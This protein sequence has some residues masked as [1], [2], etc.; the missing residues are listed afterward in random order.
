MATLHRFRQLISIFLAGALAAGFS[1]FS[2]VPERVATICE[3]QGSWFASPLSGQTVTTGGVV[4]LDRDD[5][6]L[7]G[8]FIQDAD[9]DGR[10]T[11]SD[12]VFVSL[13]ERENVVAAGD[14]VQVTGVVAE[15]YGRTQIGSTGNQVQVLVRGRPLPAAVELSLPHDPSQARIQLE[16]LEGMH[17]RIPSARV[18]APS[19]D[20]GVVWV[21]R[22]DLNLRHVFYDDPAG[23]GE[24][25]LISDDGLHQVEPP[26]A[27]GDLLNGVAGVVDYRIGMYQVH[28]RNAPVLIPGDPVTFSAPAAASR[29][30]AATFNLANLFDTFDDP[31]TKDTVLGQTEYRR[32]LYKR[33]LAIRNV[34]GEPDL[35]AVQEAE[36][37]AVL[38]SLVADPDVLRSDYQVV[39]F[40]GPDARGL[41]VALLYRADRLMVDGAYP[42]QGC[43]RLTDGLGPDGGGDPEQPQ[44]ALTCDSDG[45]GTLDGN[46]LFSRPPLVVQMR[47]YPS[48]NRAIE[49]PVDAPNDEVLVI[50]CHFKSKVEDTKYTAYTLPRR[51]EQGRFVAALVETLRGEHPGAL[52]LVLGDLNDHIQSQPLQ[53][54]I[55]AGLADVSRALPRES[56]YTY[57]FEG[58]AQSLDYIFWAPSPA[59]SPT[60]VYPAPINADFPTSMAGDIE[61]VHRSS[62]HDPLLVHFNP[63]QIQ[64]WMPLIVRK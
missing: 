49:A 25:I 13:P 52:F 22:S 54:L 47:L 27:V 20:E 38:Q 19:D 50:V 17:V 15:Y 64:G 21:V 48:D 18:V 30:S 5:A 33:A 40:D 37:R 42:S 8:F 28:L 14:L 62:D 3:I 32:R 4:V 24:R 41:D 10:T 59:W 51:I 57:I 2:Y 53:A 39:S 45:D 12:G 58:L 16:R 9:C 46:R 44:N 63:A 34:L 23:T 26:A 6:S 43:T 11:T 56:R 55:G 29:L 7:R 31:D 36:S 35:I 60:E 61:S 1:P